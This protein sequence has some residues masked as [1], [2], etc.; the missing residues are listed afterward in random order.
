MFKKENSLKVIVW[1]IYL[2]SFSMI[3]HSKISYSVTGKVL[4]E[5]KGVKGVKIYIYPV[6]SLNETETQVCETNIDGQF[7]I[8]LSSGEYITSLFLPQEYLKFVKVGLEKFTVTNKNINN[9]TFHLY[10]SLEI[11][12]AN[13]NIL[14]EIPESTPTVHYSFG[15]IPIFSIETCKKAAE[16]IMMDMV[17]EDTAKVLIGAKIGSPIIFD[18]LKNNSIYF[19]FPINNNG[20]TVGCIDMH[21]LGIRPESPSDRLSSVPISE[22]GPNDNPTIESDIPKAIETVAKKKNCTKEDIELVKLLCLAPNEGKNLYAMFKIIS[23]NERVIINLYSRDILSD[24][25][26]LDQMQADT[27]RVLTLNYIFEIKKGKNIPLM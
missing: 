8:Y 7:S 17:D 13:L 25:L 9:L 21:A 16:E 24:R 23:R 15:R 12:Q 4:R 5:D 1:M 20:K 26:T 6:N 19:Q 10:T 2:L 11:I 14:N 27:E 3:V 18:D 22:L